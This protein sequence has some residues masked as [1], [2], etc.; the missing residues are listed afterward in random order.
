LKWKNSG[1]F[2][3]GGLSFEMSIRTWEWKELREGMQREDEKLGR[4]GRSENSLLLRFM[5]LWEDEQLN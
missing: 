2:L 5:S 4:R 1:I 3:N